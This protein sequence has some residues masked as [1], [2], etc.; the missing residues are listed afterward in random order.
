MTDAAEAD[1]PT[2]VVF[3]LNN[4]NAKALTLIPK[5]KAKLK[6][7]TSIIGF[8][9]VIFCDYQ[10]DCSTSCNSFSLRSGARSA[11]QPP[12]V[13]VGAARNMQDR[14]TAFLNASTDGARSA[15][16]DT[17]TGIMDTLS[18]PRHIHH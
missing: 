15:T 6:K 1:R 4:L 10:P 7:S 13:D 8:L 12:L 3:D 11:R 18:P 5:F 16:T 2:L 14:K 17:R 9:T